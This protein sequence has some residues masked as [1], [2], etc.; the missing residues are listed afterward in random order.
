MFFIMC[1][2]FIFAYLI[3]NSVVMI[4]STSVICLLFVLSIQ[5]VYSQ[6]GSGN[7]AAVEELKSKTLLVYQY[8]NAPNYN[9]KIKQLVDSNWKYCPYVLISRKDVES[10]KKRKDIIV[11]GFDVVWGDQ[12]TPK[13]PYFGLTYGFKGI[14]I[15]SSFLAMVFARLTHYVYKTEKPYYPIIIPNNLDKDVD[16]IDIEMFF[17]SIIDIV[18]RMRMFE[19]KKNFNYHRDEFYESSKNY[20]FIKNKKL[21]LIKEEIYCEGIS[22]Y[23]KSMNGIDSLYFIPT[24][25]AFWNPNELMKYYKYGVVVSPR[26]DIEKTL[27][28][29]GDNVIIMRKFDNYYSILYYY[30]DPQKKKIVHASNE[31]NPYIMEDTKFTNQLKKCNDANGS[32]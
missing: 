19:T 1:F 22:K 16:D 2:I 5:T 15:N 28:E 29:S 11:L 20:D 32:K 23:A 13:Q 17:Y 9:A 26:K 10:Y 30:Y 18:E 3:Q 12:Q 24:D 8:E 6:F 25:T 27:K 4:K 31:V 7:R 14:N 21:M